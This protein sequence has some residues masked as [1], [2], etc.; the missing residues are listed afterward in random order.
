MDETCPLSRSHSLSQ[1][2]RIERVAQDLRTAH[3]ALVDLGSEWM[4]AELLQM[5]EE[6]DETARSVRARCASGSGQSN[7]EENPCES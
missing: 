5:V 1:A 2:V 3:A 7:T 4:P 6:L